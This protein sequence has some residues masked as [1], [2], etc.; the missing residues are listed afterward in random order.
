[1]SWFSGSKQKYKDGMERAVARAHYYDSAKGRRVAGPPP[2]ISRF[3]LKA[4][5][6][7]ARAPIVDNFMHV[8]AKCTVRV[9]VYY[10]GIAPGGDD[11]NV[12][13]ASETS[14]F[15]CR[16]NFKSANGA[17]GS[18]ILRNTVDPDDSI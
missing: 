2:R 5:R 6:P 9:P 4:M 7:H 13:P 15:V 17:T 16:Y 11:P 1:M 8:R 3:P 12:M 14:F 10:H 18:S